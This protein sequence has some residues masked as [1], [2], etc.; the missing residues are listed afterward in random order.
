MKDYDIKIKGKS[1]VTLTGTGDNT[2]IVPSEAKLDSAADKADI[3]IRDVSR[4]TLGIPKDAEKVEI[5]LE[6]SSLVIRDLTF[7]RL[8]IDGKGHIVID[9]ENTNGPVD[10]NMI[11]GTADLKVH[12][13][14]PFTT[15][16]KGKNNRI[17]CDIPTDCT[18]RNVIELN[19]KDSVLNITR[20]R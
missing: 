20:A 18:C 7:E 16:L 17:E 4:V 5:S 12:E 15:S 9:I 3:D 11:S 2:I 8:E 6:D 19:G 13:G 1:D 10:I 14:F